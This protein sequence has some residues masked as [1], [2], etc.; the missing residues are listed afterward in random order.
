MEDKEWAW[1]GRAHAEVAENCSHWAWNGVRTT[2]V[3][4]AAGSKRIR[5]AEAKAKGEQPRI[6]AGV[7]SDV[8]WRQ[9]TISRKRP[10]GGELS[11]PEKS[12]KPQAAGSP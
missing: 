4:G 1:G 10:R 7:H 6:L 8:T 9:L 12:K 3:H 2:Q 11:C 5:L